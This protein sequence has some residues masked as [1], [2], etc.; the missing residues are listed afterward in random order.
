MT[1]EL[2]GQIP[3]VT[4][5]SLNATEAA[6]YLGISPSQFYKLTNLD[7]DDPRKIRQTSYGTYPVAELERH[8]QAELANPQAA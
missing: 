5:G 8:L 4:R 3:T 2:K 1:Q 6:V 7:N